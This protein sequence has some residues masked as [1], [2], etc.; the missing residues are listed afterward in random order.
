MTGSDAFIHGQ[1]FEGLTRTRINTLFGEAFAGAIFGLKVNRW[2]GPFRSS[3]GDHLV[4]VQ[5]YEEA[6][7]PVLEEVANQVV[8]LWREQ[9]RDKALASRL[10]RL[11][12]E[13]KIVDESDAR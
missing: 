11:R 9:Q 5:K 13:Y 2:L 6:R 12:S 7:I 8:G 3:F 1:N 4:R 10:Q